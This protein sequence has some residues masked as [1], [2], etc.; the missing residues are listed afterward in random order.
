[1]DY[2]S[3]PFFTITGEFDAHVTK[4]YDGDTIHAVFKLYETW[5]KFHIRLENIDTPEMHG[6]QKNKAIE[7]TNYLR[8]LIL[9][10][11]VQLICHGFD[12]YGRV[13][14]T[15]IYDQMDINNHLV[16]KGMAKPYFGGTKS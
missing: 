3:V 13:L 14:A 8:S 7:V 6:E 2:N 9:D 1:M 15:V 12:K 16:E 5:Y 4:V 10:K 11:D